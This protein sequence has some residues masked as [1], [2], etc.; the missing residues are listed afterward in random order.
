MRLVFRRYFND[1]GALVSA[2]AE[3]LPS[4]LVGSKRI[5]DLNYKG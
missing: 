4:P 3:H 2:V 5:L 1:T